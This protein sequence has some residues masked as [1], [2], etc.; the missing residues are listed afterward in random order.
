MRRFALPF[1]VAFALCSFGAAAGVPQA[2]TPQ[3]ATATTAKPTP[4]KPATA[5][6]R[7]AKGKF[8]SCEK[9]APAKRCRDAKGKFT[10]C[11]K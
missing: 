4:A 7:D 5:H 1:A 3:P 8:E 9:Q 2:A 11:P 10:A 6:C